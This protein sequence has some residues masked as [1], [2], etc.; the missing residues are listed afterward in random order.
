MRCESGLMF[1]GMGELYHRVRCFVVKCPYVLGLSSVFCAG[2][3]GSSGVIPYYIERY[4]YIYQWPG[5]SPDL[6]VK[7]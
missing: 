1:G 7:Y 4:Y 3:V 2:Q 6:P 5:G